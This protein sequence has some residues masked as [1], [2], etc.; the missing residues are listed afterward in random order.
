M[1]SHSDFNFENLNFLLNMICDQY[2]IL[3][4]GGAGFIGSH[5]YCLLKKVLTLSLDSLIKVLIR[6]Q[7]ILEITRT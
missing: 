2:S 1:Q 5:V 6:S 7:I 4:T 3:I